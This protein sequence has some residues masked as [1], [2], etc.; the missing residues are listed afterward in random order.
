M[1]DKK[2]NKNGYMLNGILSFKGYDWWWHSFTGVN[3][4]TGEEKSFF[5]EYFIINPSRNN[6]KPVFGNEKKKPSYLMVKV[7]C[8]GKDARQLHR[9]FGIREMESDKNELRVV[10]GDCFLSEYVIKGNVTVTKEEAENRPEL[11]SDAGSMS[12]LLQIEKPISFD[13]GYGS[14]KLFR[15]LNAFEMYWHAQGMKAEYNGTVYLDGERY[16]VTPQT[17]YG[18]AD[19][20]WGSNFTKP[21]IWLSSNDLVSVM[22]GRQLKN[23]AFDIGGG[24]PKVFHIP[25]KQKLL[26]CFH[27]EGTNFEFNFSK[28]WTFTQTKFSCMETDKD[29]IWQVRTANATGAMKVKVVCPKEEMLLMRYVA[30]DGE[31]KHP[32]LWNG[33]T[34]NAY[35]KLYKRRFGLL[36]LLD[37]IV[38]GHVGC[39]YG[40]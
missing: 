12:W 30:P 11:R 8:W 22:S 27:Y 1:S 3:P 18:Y 24:C 33:G 36:K 21:W 13:V 38:A 14:S 39:E 23:S 4:K 9:Y 6:E 17:C 34:G 28:F 32:R 35:I 15:K 5:I 10:A 26:T 2:D 16:Q 19:K 7:G 29:I 40:E 31:E 37:E 25:L 20:N